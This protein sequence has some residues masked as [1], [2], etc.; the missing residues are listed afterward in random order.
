MGNLLGLIKKF[1]HMLA[2]KVN[3]N[4]MGLQV[5]KKGSPGG[6]RQSIL[7]WLLGGK[8]A[9]AFLRMP[10]GSIQILLFFGI[11]LGEESL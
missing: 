10:F 5:L 6:P 8:L 2:M 4:K 1:E 7:F 3:H 9:L 11:L